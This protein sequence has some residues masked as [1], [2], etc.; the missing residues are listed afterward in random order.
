MLLFFLQ[1]GQIVLALEVLAKEQRQM[2]QQLTCPFGV[3]PGDGTDG[4]E[5]IEQKMGIDLRLNELE[6]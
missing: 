3:A 1:G 2:Q 4:I 5:G 6:L